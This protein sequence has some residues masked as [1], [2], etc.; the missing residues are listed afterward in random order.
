MFLVCQKENSNY[1]FNVGTRIF[2]DHTA[3]NVSADYSDLV[4]SCYK[5]SIESVMFNSS[6]ET[7]SKINEWCSKATNGHLKDL[8]N[9][10]FDETLGLQT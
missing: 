7:A 1:Q 8:V 5:T 10:G 3:A 9:E 6:A 2:V 4:Q